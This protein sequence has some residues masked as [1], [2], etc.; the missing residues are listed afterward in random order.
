[1]QLN[2][3]DDFRA[4]KAIDIFIGYVSHFYA[5]L[6]FFILQVLAVP[7][8]NNSQFETQ[9]RLLKLCPQVPLF[10][11]RP[12]HWNEK[13]SAFK[14]MRWNSGY[15]KFQYQNIDSSNETTYNFENFQS[16]SR[17]LMIIGI[18]NYPD[19]GNS[20]LEA[21]LE[22]YSRK[23]PYILLRRIFLFNY[24]FESPLSSQ[25]DGTNLF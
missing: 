15:I 20:N 1:M 13:N 3:F 19:T 8:G 25:N 16:T 11:I 18:A 17:V 12:S 7:L 4:I 5:I 2:N 14:Y 23:Y 10:E 24:S 6:S 21:E 22:F 9:A